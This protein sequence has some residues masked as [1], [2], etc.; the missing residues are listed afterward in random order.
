MKSEGNAVRNRRRNLRSLQNL[1]GKKNL[2]RIPRV[3]LAGMIS[4]LLFFLMLSA[5]LHLGLMENPI[6]NQ[7]ICISRW[8]NKLDV[9]Q[10]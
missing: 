9:I 6:R 1:S 4:L 3:N 8:I 7:L 5:M 2:H 10:A